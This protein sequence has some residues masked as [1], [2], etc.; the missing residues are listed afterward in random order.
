MSKVNSYYQDAKE[1]ME[2]DLERI[3]DFLKKCMIFGDHKSINANSLNH[4]DVQFLCFNFAK[5][6]INM[7]RTK[8]EELTK[9]IKSLTKED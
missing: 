7:A 9:E 6:I 2:Y 8:R 4:T 5:E 1:N 3:E